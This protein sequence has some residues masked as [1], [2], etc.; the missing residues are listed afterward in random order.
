MPQQE[1][2]PRLEFSVAHRRIR[3]DVGIGEAALNEVKAGPGELP[4]SAGRASRGHCHG[5]S[6][7]VV[8]LK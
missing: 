1:H 8:G 2:V 4:P 3:Q 7:G 6:V 5:R